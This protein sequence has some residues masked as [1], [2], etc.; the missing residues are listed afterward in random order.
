M[1]ENRKLKKYNGLWVNQRYTYH[2]Q[3]KTN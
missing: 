3:P 2:N 1:R